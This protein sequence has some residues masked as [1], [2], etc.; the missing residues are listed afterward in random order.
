MA[1]KE[2]DVRLP[3]STLDPVMGDIISLFWEPE[4]LQAMGQT[5][6]V[7]ATEIL[8]NSLQQILGQTVLVALISSIQ[9]PMMLTKLGYLID[10][11]WST[12]LDRARACGLVHPNQR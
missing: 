2:D 7:L 5:M 11:P 12:S 1:S 3:F 10:N 6:N 8:T 4:T 9:W